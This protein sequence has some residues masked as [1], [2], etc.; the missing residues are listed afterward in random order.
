[1]F[2]TL[3]RNPKEDVMHIILASIKSG[4]LEI[5]WIADRFNQMR[6]PQIKTILANAPMI[7]NLW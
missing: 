6:S 2:I 7:S 4:G 1:M 3:Q 5:L